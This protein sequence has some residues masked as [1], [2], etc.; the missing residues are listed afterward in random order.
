MHKKLRLKATQS[1][2]FLASLS[3]T[4]KQL[5]LCRH[6]TV[7]TVFSSRLRQQFHVGLGRSRSR[8]IN[9]SLGYNEKLYKWAKVDF[10]LRILCVLWC[11]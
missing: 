2:Q 8:S 11:G 7:H 5:R 6:I 9:T 4:Q 1:Q 10:L 3:N